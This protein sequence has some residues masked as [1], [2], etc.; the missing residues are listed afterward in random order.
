M[1]NKNNYPN[2]LNISIL[3]PETGKKQRKSKKEKKAYEFSSC[4]LGHDLIFNL[5]SL[6]TQK[7]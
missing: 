2:Y 7:S 5:Y 6:G 1:Y 3:K 4:W